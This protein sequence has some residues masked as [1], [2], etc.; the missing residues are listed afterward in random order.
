MTLG[1]PPAILWVVM[2]DG[3][4]QSAAPAGGGNVNSGVQLGSVVCTGQG[5]TE[6]PIPVDSPHLYH[7][8]LSPGSS[9]PKAL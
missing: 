2:G 9:E 3:S 6:H 5:Q 8:S 1:L 4:N 7:T